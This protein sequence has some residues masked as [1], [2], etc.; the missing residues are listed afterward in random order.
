MTM[1][2]TSVTT[3]ELSP[4]E[5]DDITNSVVEAFNVSTGDVSTDVTYVATAT[6]D[7][8]IPE[9]TSEEEVV[10]AVTSTIAELLN[11]HPKDVTITSV[12]LET[13]EVEYEVASEN[14]ANAEIVQDALD[15][16]TESQ[17]EDQI[18]ET[19]PE[20]TVTRNQVENEIEVDV[21]IIVDGSEAGNIGEAQNEVIFRCL[22]D[23]Q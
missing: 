23:F 11:V 1:E 5:I 7:L 14:F 19:I 4:S 3:S 16:L 17:I 12:N 15:E 9:G 22:V 20:A 13:G 18:Q 10:D 6:L 2:I 8:S 21:A